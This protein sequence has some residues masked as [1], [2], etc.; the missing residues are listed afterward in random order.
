MNIDAES[1]GLVLHSANEP[2]TAN[3]IARRL[4]TT[5]SKVNA[6]LYMD[7]GVKF[8][9]TADAKPRWSLISSL[10]NS[11]IH[12]G[13]VLSRNSGS[14][15]NVDAPGGDWIVQV[16]EERRS[17]NDPPYRIE[18]VG[19]RQVNVIVN[20]TLI[21]DGLDSQSGSSTAAVIISAAVGLTHHL[22]LQRLGEEF[23]QQKIDLLFR[24]V[25]HA[26]G[27]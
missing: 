7:V 2:L 1:V 18:V 3:E 20:L 16:V 24:D 4:K 21:G 23:E 15:I 27:K 6:V 22:I 5:R 11:S 19:I 14:Q 12:D 13:F 9:K 8:R 25:L 10:R 26:F 17:R